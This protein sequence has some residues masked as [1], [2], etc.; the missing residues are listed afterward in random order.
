MSDVEMP[1]FG[2]LFVVAMVVVYFKDRI[3]GDE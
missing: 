3:G 1:C 2:I